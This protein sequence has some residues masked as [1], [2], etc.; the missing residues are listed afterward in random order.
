L[1]QLLHVL[2]G[3]PFSVVVAED[4]EENE[5]DED[6]DREDEYPGPGHPTAHSH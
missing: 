4:D 1:L 2:D 3:E 5:Q 6:N